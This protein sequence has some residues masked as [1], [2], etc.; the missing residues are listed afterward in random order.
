M[1][2][3][4]IDTFLKFILRDLKRSPCSSS[5]ITF[6]GIVC[7]PVLMHPG[8]ASV[9]VLVESA[10]SYSNLI[11]GGDVAEGLR[12]RMR[13]TDYDQASGSCWMP[14]VLKSVAC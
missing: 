9:R 12:R 4:A 6:D 10:L 8:V 7:E 2:L 14:H 1:C 5:I 13:Y 3:Q 11:A